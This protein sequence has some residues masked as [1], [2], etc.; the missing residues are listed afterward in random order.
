MQV[1]AIQRVFL[2]ISAAVYLTQGMRG[3]NTGVGGETSFRP[4]EVPAP[5]RMMVGGA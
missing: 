1:A 3:A 2:D 4:Q 5:L